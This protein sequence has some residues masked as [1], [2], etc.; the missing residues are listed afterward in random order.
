MA[1]CRIGAQLC[2]RRVAVQRDET[3]LSGERNAYMHAYIHIHIHI[4]IDVDIDIDIDI[5][6]YIYIFIYK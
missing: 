2:F 1:P 4:D 3:V 6:R 5:Y